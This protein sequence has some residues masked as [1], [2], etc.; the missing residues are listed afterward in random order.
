MFDAF[1]CAG[2]LTQVLQLLLSNCDGEEE[3]RNVVAECLGKLALLHP[4]EVLK[5]LQARVGAPSAS[6]RVVVRQNSMC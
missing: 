5:E 1:T 6:V 3:C 4:A 2:E